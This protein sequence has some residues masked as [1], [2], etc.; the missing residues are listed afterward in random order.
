MRFQV[1]RFTCELS[2]DYAGKVVA[3]WFGRAVA[4]KYLNKAEREQYRASRAAFLGQLSNAGETGGRS[5]TMRGPRTAFLAI[6]VAVLLAGCA[7]GGGI[8]LEAMLAD[9]NCEQAGYQ[10][11]TPQYAACRSELAR[12]SA[13]NNAAMQDFYFRQA[14]L[15][16]RNQ[17]QTCIYN[18]S[19][20]G[21]ITSGTATCR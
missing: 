8:G 6:A 18:S 16:R 7:R 19:N 2:C 11:G 20:I 1:G 3:I 14:E 5:A 21:G 9:H 13:I 15:A 17:S 12:R 10:L 4:P